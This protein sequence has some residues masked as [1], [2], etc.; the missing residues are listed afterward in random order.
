MS[1]LISF[2]TINKFFGDRL[3]TV[4]LERG[5]TRGKLSELCGIHEQAL[6]KYEK[7]QSLPAVENLKKL[8]TALE[9]SADYFIY[10]HANMDGIPRISQ[11]ELYQRYLILEELKEEDLRATLTFLDALIIKNQFEK[12]L[13]PSQIVS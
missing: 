6:M 3:K 13:Q 9:V 4:R 12:A 10:P 7:G 8:S 1:E 11:P 2:M 5:Y